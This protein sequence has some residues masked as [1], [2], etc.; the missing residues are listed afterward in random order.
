MI[1]LPTRGVVDMDLRDLPGGELVERGL[2][3]LRRGNDSCEALLVSMA[4]TR[5][6]QLGIVVPLAALPDPELRLYRMLEASYGLGAHSKY[7]AWRRRLA[8]FLRA[9]SCVRK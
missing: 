6:T 9:V 2:E 8:S 4:R 5:L 3:D 7:N 1:E